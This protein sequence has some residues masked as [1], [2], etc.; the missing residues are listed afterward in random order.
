MP[1][2]ALWFNWDWRPAVELTDGRFFAITG[3]GA[4]W[5]R[6]NAV[7]ARD[8]SITGAVLSPSAFAKTFPN[9]DASTI[10]DSPAS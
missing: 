1:E 4:S 7:S 6:L 10:P 9:A 5:E 2:V 8:V 3:P